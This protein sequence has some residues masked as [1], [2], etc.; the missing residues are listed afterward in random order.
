[1]LKQINKYDKMNLTPDEMQAHRICY[2]DTV[3]QRRLKSTG[4]AETEAEDGNLS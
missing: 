3:H 4:G 2:T 1:M